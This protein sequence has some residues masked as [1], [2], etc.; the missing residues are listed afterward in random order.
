MG[1]ALEARRG[2][3]STPC[4]PVEGGMRGVGRLLDG[5]R[6]PLLDS[7]LCACGTAA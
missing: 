6:G 5:M 7:L 4:N 1:L 3:V 2:N